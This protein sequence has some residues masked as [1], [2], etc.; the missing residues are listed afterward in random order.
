[1]LETNICIVPSIS[2]CGGSIFSI[3]VLNMQVMLSDS[4]D[5]FIFAIP[6]FADAYITGKSNWSSVAFSSINSS[7]TLSNT[8]SGS[9]PGLSIL[10]IT[11]IGFRFNAKDF[12][13]TSRVCGMTP[14]KASTNSKT[15]STVFRTR[16]TSP[17][18]SA[19][20]GV[21]T[22]FIFTPSYI[23]DVFLERIVI[24][25]SFSISPESIILS[26]TCSFS[27]NTWLC[28]NKASTNVVFPWSTCAIIAI[29][30][31]FLLFIFFPLDFYYL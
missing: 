16:S 15:P 2:H 17:P 8:F 18:K 21:S 1:M 6:F 14:S 23:T 4:S 3:I 31:I 12:F 29:F 22:M 5:K 13:R 26:D 9:A 27:L 24:P 25:L 7:I 10:F 20:P 19:C 28:F 11:T 30:L